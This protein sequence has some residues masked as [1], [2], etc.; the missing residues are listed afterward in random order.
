[1]IVVAA[2]FALL[3]VAVW[4]TSPVVSK[5]VKQSDDASLQ[6]ALKAAAAE[7]AKLKINLVWTLGEKEQRGWYLYEPLIQR[8]INDERGVESS[9]F[10]LA[11]AYWQQQS[12]FEPTGVV[13]ETTLRQMLEA[14]QSKRIKNREVAAPQSLMTAPIADFYDSTRAVELLKVER[15]TY[16]A[17]KKMIAEAVKD[18]SL[19]L[20]TTLTGEL[21][22]EERFLKIVSAFRSP[23]HQARLR[24]AAPNASRTALAVNSPHFTGRAL[25]LYVGGEPVTTKDANRVIQINTPVY[26]WLVKNAERFGFY[27]YYY[28]P[29]HWEYVPENRKLS[30]DEHR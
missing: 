7:N 4:R 8:L 12:G 14:F 20:K 17:Y 15:E 1:M 29:W 13:E 26:K 28:E 23:E 19:G 18:K 10:A 27:P 3:F 6:F 9:E 25:D 24:E 22:P 11:L 2:F 5:D 21:A 30:T 16:A